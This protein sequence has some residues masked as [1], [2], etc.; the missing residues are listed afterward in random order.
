MKVVEL[1]FFGRLSVD[2]TAEVLQISP[3]KRSAR[4]ELAKAW[5]Q[6]ELKHKS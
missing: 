4:L 3:Q 2:E 1:P 6:R 5:L